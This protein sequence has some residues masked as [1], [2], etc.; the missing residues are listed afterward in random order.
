MTQERFQQFYSMSCCN[1]YRTVTSTEF[2]PLE[3][4]EREAEDSSKMEEALDNVPLM[5]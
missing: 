1:F 2:V 5:I 4:V 3:T